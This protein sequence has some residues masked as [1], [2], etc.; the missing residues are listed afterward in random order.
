MLRSRHTIPLIVLTVIIGGLTSAVAL[1]VD[2]IPQQASEQAQVCRDLACMM[3]DT[4]LRS[5]PWN[6]VEEVHPRS[7]ATSWP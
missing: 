1:F 6:H 4:P 7:L 2:W 5:A 3:L